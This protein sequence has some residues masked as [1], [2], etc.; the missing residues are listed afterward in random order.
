EFIEGGWKRENSRCKTLLD[1]IDHSG[2]AYHKKQIICI[3]TNQ[4]TF[5]SDD[6][7]MGKIKNIPLT[8]PI[9]SKTF[10]NG[11]YLYLIEN[12]SKKIQLHEVN[13]N[14]P[15]GDTNGAVE[16]KM[17]DLEFRTKN[18]MSIVKN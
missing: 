11:S 16:D 7:F 18:V 17:P 15:D 13:L 8:L 14:D 6:E 10:Q 12:K 2:I 1:N 5:Y 9:F 3:S 4:L